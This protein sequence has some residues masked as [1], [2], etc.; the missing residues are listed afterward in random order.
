MVVGIYNIRYRRKKEGLPQAEFQA[1]HS[2]LIFSALVCLF[3]L[4]MPWY[5]PEGGKGDVSFWYATYCAVGIGLMVGMGLYY[6]LWVKLLPRWRNYS[7]RTETLVN[8]DDGSVTHRLTKIPNAQVEEWD[9]T[10]DDA[11]NVLIEAASG[12]TRDEN[13]HLIK[14]IRVRDEAAA[15][16]T[17]EEK[18]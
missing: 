3:L 9:R 6:Y 11:G 15:T 14:R 5:P 8:E 13:S 1:W 7:I 2:A 10:H 16:Y 17:P 12:I 18:V 4:I